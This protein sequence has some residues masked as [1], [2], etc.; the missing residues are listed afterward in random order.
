VAEP[1]REQAHFN[2]DTYAGGCVEVGSG[3]GG[4]HRTRIAPRTAACYGG[5]ST[6]D[7][8]ASRRTGRG[9]ATSPPRGC[10]SVRRQTEEGVIGAVTLARRRPRG[11]C[12]R[13]QGYVD[14]AP[15][16]DLRLAAPETTTDLELLESKTTSWARRRRVRHPVRENRKASAWPPAARRMVK[17]ALGNSMRIPGGDGPG[18]ADRNLG[19]ARC[20]NLRPGSERPH[21]AWKNATGTR[22]MLRGTPRFVSSTAATSRRGQP[23]RIPEPPGDRKA[24]CRGR[25]PEG[26]GSGGRRAFREAG[27]KTPGWVGARDGPS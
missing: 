20:P 13:A 26:S 14:G 9:S 4:D 23:R 3:G 6:P 19:S 8:R 27:G 7:R 5:R 17:V 2:L 15:G 10:S 1:G 11:G 16:R 21:R 18:H 12:I 22:Q 24:D 25:D